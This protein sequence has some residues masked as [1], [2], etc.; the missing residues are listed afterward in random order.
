MSNE[1]QMATVGRLVTERAQAKREMALLMAALK[2]YGTLLHACGAELVRQQP[3]TNPGEA[4]KSVE[5]VFQK[6]GFD[7]LRKLL[8]E[9]IALEDRVATVT[10]SLHA[11]GAE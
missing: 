5:G 8:M 11:A 1:E 3:P 4:L 7:N 10:Q 9:Y 6:G 2:E